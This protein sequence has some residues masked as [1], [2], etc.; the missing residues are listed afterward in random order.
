[1]PAPSLSFI[2]TATTLL[3]LGGF[4]LLTDPNFLHRGQ[5]AYLGKGMWSRRRT[6]PAAQPDQLPDLDAVVLSHLHGDHFDR[7][8]RHGLDKHVPV[9]TT[10]Q[11]A[12]RLHRWGFAETVPLQPWNS[13]ELTGDGERLRITAVPGVHAPGIVDRVMPPVIGTVLE[14]R[15]ANGGSTVYITGDVLFRPELSEVSRR[16]PDLDTMVVHLGGTRIL[17]LL[18]TMDARQGA[19]LVE[20]LRPPVT[21]PVHYDDYPVFKSPLSDFLDEVRR[22]GLPGT[23]RT[24]HRG[25]TVELGAGQ[26]TRPIGSEER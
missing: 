15:G 14:H 2:G 22:R 4:T 26:E 3:R 16:F 5:R 7:A 21:V 8:A 9:V 20:L 11:A 25:E 13:T 1:M 12:R 24:V 18:L 19:D 10:M 17:G 6:E 23:V